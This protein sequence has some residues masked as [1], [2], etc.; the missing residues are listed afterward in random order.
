MDVFERKGGI[1]GGLR[2]REDREVWE[3]IETLRVEDRV[4]SDHFP[5]VVWIKGKDRRVSV[6]RGKG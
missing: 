6:V 1:G 3:R 4:E 5:V 2:N